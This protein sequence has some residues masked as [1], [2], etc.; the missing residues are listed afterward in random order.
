MGCIVNDNTLK[1]DV[2]ERKAFSAIPLD[3]GLASPIDFAEAVVNDP[4]K[5]YNITARLLENLRV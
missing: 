4:A 1:V 2:L 3:D 5:F